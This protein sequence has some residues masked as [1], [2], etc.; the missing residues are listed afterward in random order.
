MVVRGMV[1][2]IAIP[3]YTIYTNIKPLLR[4]VQLHEFMPKIW[5]LS[6]SR[7]WM[8]WKN[9]YLSPSLAIWWYLLTRNASK[10]IQEPNHITQPYHPHLLCQNGG[11]AGSIHARA[12]SEY[13][14]HPIMFGQPEIPCTHFL[15]WYN[16]TRVDPALW[17]YHPCQCVTIDHLIVK[18]LLEIH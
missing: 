6:C 17:L 1:Y 14:G 18:R 7:Y 8:A 5:R 2:D 4:H 10:C 16:V 11:L 12:I 15:S 13:V 9:G 3:C